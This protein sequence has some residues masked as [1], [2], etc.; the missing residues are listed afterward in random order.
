MRKLAIP[1]RAER[2]PRHRGSKVINQKDYEALA[3]FR[4]TLRRFLAFSE[5]AARVAGLRP[6]QHQAL[7]AIKGFPERNRVTVSELA[8]RLMIRHHSAVELVDRLFRI[9]LI[10]R[11]GDMADRRRIVI[12]LTAKAE[13]TLRT[14]STAHLEEVRRLGPTLTGLLDRLGMK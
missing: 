10:S 3:E 11:G 1:K 14:L 6:Q 8:G 4:F 12:S 5:S 13:R 9:G 2:Q 7:L